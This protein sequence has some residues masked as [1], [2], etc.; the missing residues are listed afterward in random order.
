[1]LILRLS[2]IPIILGLI[3]AIVGGNKLSDNPNDTSDINEGEKFEKAGGIMFLIGYVILFGATV[4][5]GLEFRNL[6]WGEKRILGAVVAALPLLAVRLLYSLISD[7]ADNNTFNI[8]YGNATVQ[9]CMAIV[10]EMIVTVFYL[11]AG[12]TAPSWKSLQGG[13]DQMAMQ[14]KPGQFRQQV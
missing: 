13:P 5:T 9:L 4:V 3:L 6:P 14:Q 7:F 8:L 12:V 11:I 2:H 1:M 10:E